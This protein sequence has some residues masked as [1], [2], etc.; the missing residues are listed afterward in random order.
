[1]D[2]PLLATERLLVREFVSADLDAVHTLLDTEIILEAPVTREE[3]QAWLTWTELGYRQLARLNQPPYGERA[4]VL[5]EDGRVIGAC[6]YVPVLNALGQIPSLHDGGPERPGLLSAAVGLYYVVS[7]AYRGQGY[8]TEAVRALID[9][10]F[11][12]MA[13][14]RIVA[15]TTFDNAA[16]IAVM[17]RL[18][19]RI[20]RNPRTTP[21][22]LQVVG[23][24][25]HPDTT[26]G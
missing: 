6:G 21:P 20:E 2:V 3:R 8:A 10:A 5:K 16:S 12:H 18:G 7:P 26:S 14:A 1:M 9:H 25:E 13:L 19:M 4:I 11:V 24:L 23:V 22:W 17:H 15:T